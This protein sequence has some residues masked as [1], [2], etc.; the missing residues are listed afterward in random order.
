[1]LALIPAMAVIGLGLRGTYVNTERN[2]R[3]RA[4]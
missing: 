1:M 3:A 4:F 2:L